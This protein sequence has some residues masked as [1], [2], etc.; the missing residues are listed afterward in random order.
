MLYWRLLERGLCAPA[1]TPLSPRQRDILILLLGPLP[2]MKICEYLELSRGTVH[3]RVI[4][5]YEI[6]AV[7]SR[8]ELCQLW[9]AI[10]PGEKG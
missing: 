5:L 10:V 3:N 9:F 4:E 8:F 1:E 6:F 7:K 2:E